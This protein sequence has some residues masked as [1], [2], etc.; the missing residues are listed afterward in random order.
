MLGVPDHLIDPRTGQPQP[1]WGW[2]L[3][4]LFIGAVWLMAAAFAA[5]MTFAYAMTG[6][7]E[8]LIAGVVP[9]VLLALA[10]YGRLAA[11]RRKR[12]QYDR[13]LEAYKAALAKAAYWDDAP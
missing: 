9:G 13:A 11:L 8:A 12:R 7:W 2:V 4:Q 5:I 1:H 10:G 6:R 3:E